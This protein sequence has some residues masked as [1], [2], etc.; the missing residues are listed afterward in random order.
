MCTD[1]AQHFHVERRLLIGEL[2]RHQDLY[3]DMVCEYTLLLHD[4]FKATRR[5]GEIEGSAPD[6]NSLVSP[7]PLP[8][9]GGRRT[10][11]S[12][13]MLLENLKLKE[14]NSRLKSRHLSMNVAHLPKAHC[15]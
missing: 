15:A 14:E 2:K 3:R 7:L 13:A 5:V 9:R 6:L 1:Q 12:G 11:S 4:C 10:M 8:M